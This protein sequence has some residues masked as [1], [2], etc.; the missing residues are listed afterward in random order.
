MEL[1]MMVL[2][3]ISS[4][5]CMVLFKNWNFWCKCNVCLVGKTA[6]VTGGASGLGYQVALALA[7]KGC[8]VIIADISDSSEV[9]ERI[10]RLTT[11]QLIIGK[12]IELQSLQ[13]VRDFASDI[14]KTESR[15]D[16]L[17]C[18]AGIGEYRKKYTTED[19]LERTMHINYFGHFLLTHLLLDLLK[20]SAPSRIVFT[21]SLTAYLSDLSLENLHPQPEYYERLFIKLNGGVYS[22][23]KLALTAAAKS[24]G[25]KLDGTGVTANVVHPGIVKTDIFRNAIKNDRN[26]FGMF[27][28]IFVYLLG[29][30]PT[31]GAQTLIHVAQSEETKTTTGQ[32]FIEGKIRPRPLQLT[33]TFCSQLW[34]T[35]IKCTGLQPQ[36]LGC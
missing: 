18:N 21:S 4:V 22:N 11:N 31:E 28:L 7:S 29:K 23:S 5:I 30:T 20:K 36:E 32:S 3:A 13:S 34:D 17:V 24:F 19:G 1:C 10:K 15:L 9:I 26:I 25:Q 12:K 35:S 27:F 2:I 8:R 14:L 6:I 16:I 33:D